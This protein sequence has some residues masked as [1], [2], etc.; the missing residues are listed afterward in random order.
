M[1]APEVNLC[2]WTTENS[3]PNQQGLGWAV[4]FKSVQMK[5]G[6]PVSPPWAFCPQLPAFNSLETEESSA[7]KYPYIILQGFDIY[8]VSHLGIQQAAFYGKVS[9]KKIIPIL[10]NLMH[11]YVWGGVCVCVE[12]ERVKINT[13][14]YVPIDWEV[15]INISAWLV[16]EINSLLLGDFS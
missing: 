9:E 10:R 14:A 15:P 2:T 13:Q 6:N 11:I 12:C 3:T 5:Q 4:N 1:L 8:Y 16:L 7:P